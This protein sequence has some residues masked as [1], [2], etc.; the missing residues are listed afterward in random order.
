MTFNYPEV[1][2][3]AE[4]PFT[5]GGYTLVVSDEW[6]QTVILHFNIVSIGL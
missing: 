1:G 3:T 6:N 2:A 5:A 4:H